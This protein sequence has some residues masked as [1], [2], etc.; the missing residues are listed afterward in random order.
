MSN[1]IPIL[2]YHRIDQ[3]ELSTSTAPAVFASHLEWLSEH[4]WRSLTAAELDF[5]AARGKCIPAK[6]FLLTFDDGYESVFSDALPILKSLN[7]G[8]LCFLSTKSIRHAVRSDSSVSQGDPGF[9]SW[10]QARE[11]QSGGWMEFHSHTHEHRSLLDLTRSELT[12]DLATSLDCLTHELRL[13]SSHFR[14]LAWPWGESHDESRQIA[15]RFGFQYQYTVA[16]SAFLHGASLQNVPRTCYDGATLTNFII[17]FQL[18]T[19]MCSSLWHAGYPLARKLR[20]PGFTI[21]FRKETPGTS[22]IAP[23]RTDSPSEHDTH[24]LGQAG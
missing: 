11:L 13:P 15:A 5:Y 16:R 8:A 12:Q 24:N 6:S 21:A 18:Q 22:I 3:E 2:L 4:G 19:G 1:C 17:Q 23:L 14:H 9:L 10:Q 20:R 7:F